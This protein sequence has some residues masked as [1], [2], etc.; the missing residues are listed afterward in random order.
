MKIP[1]IESGVPLP[2]SNRTP[3]E[4]RPFWEA[5]MG[6]SV[7]DSFLIDMENKRDS[8]RRAA[9]IR[10]RMHR[11]GRKIACRCLPDGTVR[12]WRRT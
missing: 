2:L 7:G 5:V 10:S 4:D 3:E 9:L 12:L 6:M 11:Y 8:L 1:T